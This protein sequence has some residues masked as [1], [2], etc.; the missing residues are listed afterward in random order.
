MKLSPEVAL[1]EKLIAALQERYGKDRDGIHVTDLIYCLREVYFR[2]KY[3]QPITETELMFFVDG[4]ERHSILAGL[5][6]FEAEKSINYGS[7]AGTVDM[8]A[9]GPVEIK[10]TRANKGLPP[11]YLKQ[12]GYYCAML[13]VNKGF[14]LVQRL[15]NRDS[16]WDLQSVEWS[17]KELEDMRSELVTNST[18]LMNAIE[19]GNP[20]KL[21]K[22]NGDPELSWKCRY[23]KYVEQCGKEAS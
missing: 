10:T 1:K 4:A 17:N 12:L 15:N 19:T 3:P 9:E 8:I 20:S 7:V 22:H 2:K 16:P 23:C 21:A 14:L 5:A 6:G 13:D 18:L 11:H